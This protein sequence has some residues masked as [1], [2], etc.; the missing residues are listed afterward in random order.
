M[1]DVMGRRGLA[2]PVQ[3]RELCRTDL[4]RAGGPGQPA[5]MLGPAVFTR[6]AARGQEAL[7]HADALPRK[8]SGL[9]CYLSI[10]PVPAAERPSAPLQP[11]PPP[12]T[13][14]SATTA[15]SCAAPRAGRGSPIPTPPSLRLFTMIGTEQDEPAQRARARPPPAAAGFPGPRLLGRDG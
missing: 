12:R 4:L 11:P 9:L 2:C 15:A 5:A 13:H 14:A 10:T 3:S 7:S 8:G 1:E 6:A